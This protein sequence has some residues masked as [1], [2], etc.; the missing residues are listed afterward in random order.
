MSDTASLELCKELDEL[1]NYKWQHETQFRWLCL[2][3]LI[4][5]GSSPEQDFNSWQVKHL[6]YRGQYR[7]DWYGAYDAGYLLRKLPAR[8]SLTKGEYYGA[9]WS[10]EYGTLH[11]SF[12]GKTPEDALVKLCLKLIEAGILPISRRG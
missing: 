2:P 10:N 7:V 12:T 3:K 4:H 11:H 6:S 8:I 5:K 1:T 9:T